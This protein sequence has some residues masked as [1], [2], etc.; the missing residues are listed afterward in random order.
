MATTTISPSAYDLATRIRPV[1]Y[2]S[3]RL[4]HI[5]KLFKNGRDTRRKLAIVARREA[6][7]R[8][9]SALEQRIEDAEPRGVEDVVAQLIYLNHSVSEILLSLEDGKTEKFRLG[10]EQRMQRVIHFLAAEWEIDVQK[11]GGDLYLM[12]EFLPATRSVVTL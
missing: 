8:Q 7:E 12:Q 10:V 3:D 6:V 4:D 9:W 1:V 2:L 5:I 11:I